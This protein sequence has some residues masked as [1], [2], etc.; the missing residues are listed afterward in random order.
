MCCD[1]V[2]HIVG[3]TH[4][5]YS[6]EHSNAALDLSNFLC[7]ICGISCDIDQY[8]MSENITDWG[9]WN[10]YK[11]KECANNNGFVLLIC[12]SVMFKQL[13]HPDDSP[14]IQ[15]KAGYM[16][17]LALN[18]LISDATVTHCIIPVCFDKVSTKTV[19]SSLCGRT[20]YSL[21]YKKL[22]QVA[23]INTILNKSEF[24][25]LQSLVFK[26]SGESEVN[27]PP[28]GKT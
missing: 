22:I 16:N 8:H 11:I 10:E 18:A 25:S 7:Q 23:D 9:M 1:N 12:S 21:S 13:S 6:K 15:M 17:S 27:K 19:P 24:K 2:F 5:I 14:C 20:I 26:L 28:L 4:I 3:P